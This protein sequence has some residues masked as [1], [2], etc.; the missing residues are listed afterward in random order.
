MGMCSMHPDRRRGALDLEP[1]RRL[2]EA[3]TAQSS[4]PVLHL[5]GMVP[6]QE[7]LVDRPLSQVHITRH[8]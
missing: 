5:E 3:A 8:A 4:L 1:I 2:C 6:L 7:M